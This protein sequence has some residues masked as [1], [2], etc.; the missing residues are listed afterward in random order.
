[1]KGIHYAISSQ[2]REDRCQLIPTKA[3]QVDYAYLGKESIGKSASELNILRYHP[4][5]LESVHMS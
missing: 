2:L 5:A 1:M 4:Y 3:V